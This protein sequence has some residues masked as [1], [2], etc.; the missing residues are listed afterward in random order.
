MLIFLAKADETI[1]FGEAILDALFIMVVVFAILIVLMFIIKGVSLYLD[2]NINKKE[3]KEP[4]IEV[5]Q[6]I[7]ENVLNLIEVSEEEAALIMAIVSDQTEIPLEELV[8]KS[9]K[10]IRSENK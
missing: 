8:F 7:K 10:L 1:G 9:I 6:S 2:R 3:N 5:K 4:V